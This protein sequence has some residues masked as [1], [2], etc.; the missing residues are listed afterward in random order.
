MGQRHGSMKNECSKVISKKSKRKK[1]TK[2]GV[3]EL[4][5]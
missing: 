5:H 2:D 3:G 1:I 4:V